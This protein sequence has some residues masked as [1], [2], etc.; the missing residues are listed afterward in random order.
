MGIYVEI[1]Q[2]HKGAREKME[3]DSEIMEDRMKKYGPPKLFFKTYGDM[4]RL[5]DLYAEESNQEQINEGH[6][7][8]LKQVLLKVLRSVWSPEIS[9]NY[10]D[11]RNY[12]SISEECANGES[13]NVKE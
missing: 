4:C 3:K 11:A 2:G 9:D 5:L 7:A 13:H 10:C 8:A 12:I 6:I 1:M